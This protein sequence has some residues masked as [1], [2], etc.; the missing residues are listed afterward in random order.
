MHDFVYLAT[1]K[2]IEPN[3]QCAVHLYYNETKLYST[4]HSDENSSFYRKRQ[5]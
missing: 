5:D 1:T 2:S 3:N 4:A